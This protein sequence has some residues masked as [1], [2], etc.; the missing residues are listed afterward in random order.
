[1]WS[2]TATTAGSTPVRWCRVVST[3]WD[4]SWWATSRWAE[5]EI[6]NHIYPWD[7]FLTK[8]FFPLSGRP[9]EDSALRG[10]WCGISSRSAIRVSAVCAHIPHGRDSAGL[11]DGPC[12]R[13]SVSWS[14]DLS[15]PQYPYSIIKLH[16]KEFIPKLFAGALP[17]ESWKSSPFES[18]ESSWVNINRITVHV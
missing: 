16:P 5:N 14:A 13:G 10:G 9:C 11:L 4:S 15:H 1:M 7:P 6:N 3:L 2:S 18:Y 8:F 17:R 12:A